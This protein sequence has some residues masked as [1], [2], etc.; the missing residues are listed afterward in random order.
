[1]RKT[2]Y[3]MCVDILSAVLQ[4]TNEKANKLAENNH[5]EFKKLMKL[6]KNELLEMHNTAMNVLTNCKGE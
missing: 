3:D 4:C 1:M 5:Y 6:N 2:K